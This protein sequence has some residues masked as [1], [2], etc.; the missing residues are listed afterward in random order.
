MR[1][2]T[3][4]ETQ[5]FFFLKKKKKRG[6]GG[7]KKKKKKKKGGGVEHNGSGGFGADGGASCTETGTQD[8]LT[9]ISAEFT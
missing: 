7:G 2:F 1:P 4:N 3:D 5:N 9:R 6:G 8:E